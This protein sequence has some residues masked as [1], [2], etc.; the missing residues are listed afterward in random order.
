MKKLI[1]IGLCTV[2]LLVMLSGCSYDQAIIQAEFLEMLEEPAEIE[3]IAAVGFF[4]DKNLGKME[5]NDADQMVIAYEDYIFTFNNESLEY[6]TFL[7]QFKKYISQPLSELYQIKIEEQENPIAVNTVLQMSWRQITDR[8]MR[9]ELFIKENSKNEQIKEEAKSIYEYYIN[10]ILMGTTGT[11]IFSYQDGM[12][13]EDAK[14]AYIGFSSEYPD[15]LITTIFNEYFSYLE[16]IN[17]K[18]NY[19]NTTEVKIFYDTCTYLVS[20]AGKRV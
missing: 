11:P 8:A 16:S 13:S 20:E 12:F 3:S 5:T 19:K 4:L 10:A 14:N 2:V 18:L 15:T 7:E 17:F 1:S 9:L 6:R